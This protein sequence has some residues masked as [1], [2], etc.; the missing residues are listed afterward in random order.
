MYR[1]HKTIVSVVLCSVIMLGVCGGLHAQAN[2]PRAV[3]LNA[4]AAAPQPPLPDPEQDWETKIFDVKY[5]DLNA[6][7]GVLMMFRARISASP[8]LRVLSVRAPKEIMPAIEDAIKRFDVPT[9]AKKSIELTIYVLSATDQQD[10]APLPPPLQPVVTQL[11]NVFSYAGYKL[12][13]TLIIRG[14]DSEQ[15]ST[16]GILPAFTVATA[17]TFYSFRGT[18]HVR[19]SDQNEPIL[20]LDQMNFAVQVPVMTAGIQFQYTDVAIATDV[21]IPRGQ[22]VVIGKATV[23][24]NALILVMS[25]KVLD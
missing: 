4:Q 8:A 14:A 24:E 16:R 6:L 12:L 1:C 20:R 19:S 3:F 11:K 23:R 21:E 18:F 2:P 5:A 10:T 9:P 13:D 15:T 7:T 22:Q 25:A 17:L